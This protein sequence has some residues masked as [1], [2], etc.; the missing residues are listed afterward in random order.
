MSRHP[1][2][3]CIALVSWWDKARWLSGWKPSKHAAY[4][5]SERE[6]RCASATNNAQLHNIIFHQRSGVIFSVSLHS[7][8]RAEDLSFHPVYDCSL[9]ELLANLR[10]D[11]GAN[12]ETFGTFHQEND[13][14]P[15]SRL[16]EYQYTRGSIS[17]LYPA[18]TPPIAPASTIVARSIPAM[19]RCVRRLRAMGVSSLCTFPKTWPRMYE[20]ILS[21]PN[22]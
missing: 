3:T 19:T 14:E 13:L 17:T 6:K 9:R 18:S 10:F 8:S 20:C 7:F 16:T 1:R 21:A 2:I 15:V 11:V 22:E 4:D 12:L 5:L